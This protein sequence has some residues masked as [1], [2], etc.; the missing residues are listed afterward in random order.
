MQFTV[1]KHKNF[2]EKYSTTLEDYWA[3]EI[4]SYFYYKI[5]HFPALILVNYNLDFYAIKYLYKKMKYY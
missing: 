4:F 2:K 3:N 5:K 1:F